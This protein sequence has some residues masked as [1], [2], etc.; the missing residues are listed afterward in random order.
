MRVRAGLLVAIVLA[1]TGVASAAP[2]A[3]DDLAAATSIAVGEHLVIANDEATMEAQENDTPSCV[4]DGLIGRTRWYSVTPARDGRL[5]FSLWGSFTPVIVTFSGS[6]YGSLVEVGCEAPTPTVG[7]DTSKAADVRA[8]ETYLL[9]IGGWNSDPGTIEGSVDLYESDPVTPRPT[10]VNDDIANALEITV[11]FEASRIR[12]SGATLDPREAGLCTEA[13]EGGESLWLRFTPAESGRITTVTWTGGGGTARA[14]LFTGSSYADLEVVSCGPD[15]NYRPM[16]AP[17]T[18]GVPYLVQLYT[19]TYDETD[20]VYLSIDGVFTR[21][22]NDDRA[23]AREFAFTSKEHTAVTWAATLEADEPIPACRI[24]TLMASPTK[25]RLRS[26]VWYRIPTG[27]GGR[28][29]VDAWMSDFDAVLGAYMVVGG[30]LVEVGC[31]PSSV[32]VGSSISFVAVAGRT[33]LVQ[34]MGY[35]DLDPY[36]PGPRGAGVLRISMT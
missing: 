32:V 14:S 16:D 15:Y 11:P 2:P 21:P 5:S 26:S 24:A 36:Y 28:V 29:R 12:P 33:Y 35:E 9:Q 10:P 31:S 19:E 23:D 6:G 34:A 1:T 13:Y 18:A 30:D 3:N 25:V 20:E 8:G 7:S 17:V 22:A 4:G 27:V